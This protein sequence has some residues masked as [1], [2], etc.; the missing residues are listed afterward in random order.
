MKFVPAQVSAH[1]E[2]HHVALQADVKSMGLIDSKSRASLQFTRER[3]PSN[4]E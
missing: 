2:L 1:V 3:L 4:K